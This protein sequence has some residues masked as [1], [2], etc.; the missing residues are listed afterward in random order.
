MSTDLRD[1]ANR[2]G[3][4]FGWFVVGAS[5]LGLVFGFS[6]FMAIAFG[7][8]I[9][10]LQAEFGWSRTAISGG[11]TIVNTMVIFLAFGAGAL[12]DRFGVRRTMLV[13]IFAF[14]LLI[15]SMGLLTGSIWHYYVLYVLVPIAG[16][17]IYPISYSRLILNWFDRHRGIALGIALSG[18]GLAG[19]LLPPLIQGVIATAGWR[20]AYVAF[21]LLVLLVTLPTALRYLHER[22]E[23]RGLAPDGDPPGTHTAE[24]AA[25]YHGGD[26]LAHALTQR[27]FWQLLVAFGLLGAISMGALTHLAALVGD[28]GYGPA[29]IS[30]VMFTYGL[31]AIIG[32]VT[33]GLLVDRYFAPYVATGF[34]ISL[35]ASMAMLAMGM[36]GLALYVAVV[37]FGLALGAEFDLMSFMVSR[38]QGLASYGKI[39]GTVY[40]VF[41]AGA[42]LGPI[43]LG[44]S[45]DNLDGYGPMLTVFAISM[46]VVIVLIATLGPYRWQ[47]RKDE[48]SHETTVV[49]PGV[50]V[51]PQ[52]Q[53]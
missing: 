12:I 8:F 37:M 39:Y 45:Y 22:P 17:G 18:V 4:F 20:Y 16:I 41:S 26:T 49:A 30:A 19:M 9:T 53:R 43:S 1:P 11:A 35:T 38:Y 25:K 10:H 32:R 44:W 5:L 51:L 42:A 31:A 13:S 3:V 52:D 15:C 24:V 6:S 14:A 36:P 29:G 27:V 34:M 47:V 21:G 33:C 46:I 48:P 50:T 2:Q 7:Q 40:G 23:D 28:L